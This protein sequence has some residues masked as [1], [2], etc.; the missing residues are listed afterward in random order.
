MLAPHVAVILP[1]LNEAAVIGAVV[2]DFRQALPQSE[3]YVF[4]NGSTDNTGAEAAAA[5]AIVRRIRQRGK[6]NVVRQAFAQVDA[7]VYVLADGD[8]T[9]DA[10]R[11]PELVELLWDERLDMVVGAREHQGESGA[12]RRGHQL[13][14][15]LFNWLVHRLFAP[16]FIDIFSGY[17]V[18]SRPFVKSFPALATGFESETEMNLHAIQLGLPCLEVPTRYRS[19]ERG[20]R[21]QA[22]NLP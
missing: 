22:Q 6:G 5:G 17:R 18:F 11:A 8:G 7:D 2:A 1:C 20:E 13:G 14:N 4:D 9:Y 19:R 16:T 15:R 10:A 3:I 21:K 12:Y